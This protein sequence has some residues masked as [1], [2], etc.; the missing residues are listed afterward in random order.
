MKLALRIVFSL[1]FFTVLLSTALS[2]TTRLDKI[3]RKECMRDYTFLMTAKVNEFFRSHDSVTN[4]F[5]I[6][7]SMMMDFLIVSF[8]SLFILYWKTYRPIITY[9]LFFG[10]RIIVQVKHKG[11]LS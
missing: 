7:S 3:T 2:T 6:Y 9:V 8:I 5:I 4:G 10:F 11:G 1:L